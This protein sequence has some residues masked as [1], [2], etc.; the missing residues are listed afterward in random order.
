LKVGKV[1]EA[2]DALRAIDLMAVAEDAVDDA[3]LADL[4]E[5]LIEI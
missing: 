3:G 4:G 5:V 2:V 1:E